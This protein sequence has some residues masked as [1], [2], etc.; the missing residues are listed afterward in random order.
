[1]ECAHEDREDENM[2]KMDIKETF[3]HD[4]DMIINE[5]YLFE[6]DVDQKE[7]LSN[8]DIKRLTIETSYSLVQ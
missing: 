5:I 6:D 8:E 1:M 7:T 3:A 2:Y 4:V